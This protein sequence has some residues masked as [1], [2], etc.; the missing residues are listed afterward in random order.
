MIRM[1][2]KVWLL[3]IKTDCYFQVKQK[4]TVQAQFQETITLC[5]KMANTCCGYA[6]QVVKA[7]GSWLKLHC[8]IR[9]LCF[10]S[11]I[12]YFRLSKT[13]LKTM[14]QLS[15]R[16]PANMVPF[17]QNQIELKLFVLNVW[18]MPEILGSK[19]KTIRM[20]YIEH[21]W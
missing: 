18:G 17:F 3:T 2:R 1:I 19:D 20:V 5:T 16:C 11:L 12:V 14:D 10:A 9:L 13:N 6:V 8:G 15:Q 4:T 21:I 7:V